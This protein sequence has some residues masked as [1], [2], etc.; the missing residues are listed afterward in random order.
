MNDLL[1]VCNM[2]QFYDKEDDSSCLQLHEDLPVH[3]K[4]G[5]ICGST[6]SG[7]SNL[8]T[9]MITKQLV[10]DRI[11]V[12]SRHIDQACYNYIKKNIEMTEKE[13]KKKYNVSTEIIQLWSDDIN[14]LPDIGSFDKNYRN[15]VIIDDFSVISRPLEKKIVD[16]YTRCRHHNAS[17]WFLAQF[18]FGIPRPIRLNCGY[19]ILFNNSNAKEVRLLDTEL[20]CFDKGVFKKIYNDTLSEKYSFM[21]ID[22]ATKNP[23]RRF[24]KGFSEV[25][26]VNKY[27]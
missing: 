17:I 1:K 21:F 16:Y 25:I 10:F 19:V 22:N 12:L 11:Y 27:K 7:K 13:M 23:S 6:G 14:E 26:D 9:S 3:K 2:D 8:I 18:Y 15:L 24:R 20:S 4:H 5:I